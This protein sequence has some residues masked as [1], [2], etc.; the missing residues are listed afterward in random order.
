MCQRV[1]TI[2]SSYRRDACEFATMST[3]CGERVADV[4]DATFGT[5]TPAS[6]SPENLLLPTYLCS[7]AGGELAVDAGAIDSEQAGGFGD[8]AVGAREGPLD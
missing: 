5:G 8:V 2:A 6:K 1:S 7:P 3:N 4:T